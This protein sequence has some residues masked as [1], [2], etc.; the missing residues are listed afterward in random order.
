MRQMK[1]RKKA[2]VIDA[3]QVGTDNKP[4]WID[5]AIAND[6][7]RC[8]GNNRYTLHNDNVSEGCLEAYKDQWIIRG[9]KGELYVCDNDIFLMT[10]EAG[11]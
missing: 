9:I 10:Y 1:Y 11:E 2:I 3:W 8:H 5:V 7:A 6:D 4:H